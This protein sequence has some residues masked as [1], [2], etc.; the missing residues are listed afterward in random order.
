MDRCA[1]LAQVLASTASIPQITVSH[2]LLDFSSTMVNVLPTA[3]TLSLMEFAQITVQADN[4]VLVK[5]V[6]PANLLVLLAQAQQHALPVKMEITPTM[7][8]VFLHALQT[9]FQLEV[10]ALIALLPAMDAPQTQ[11]LA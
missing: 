1:S 7:A 6:P 11:A 5:P 8:N 4:I 3:L 10:T 2:A 9:L